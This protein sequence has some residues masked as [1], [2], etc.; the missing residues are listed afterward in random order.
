MHV[1]KVIRLAARSVLEGLPTTGGRVYQGRALPIDAAD[2]LPAL[3]V[4]VIEERAGR[5]AQGLVERRVIV[6][7]TAAAAGTAA[8]DNLDQIAVEVEEGLAAWALIAPL[9]KDFQFT[10]AAFDW[11][12]GATGPAHAVLTFEAVV[13][14]VEGT[15][16]ETL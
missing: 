9:V 1:R 15:P 4:D 16:Q 2:R 5:R 7:V 3:G 11:S 8:E 14:T 6:R 12:A 10:G 13:H